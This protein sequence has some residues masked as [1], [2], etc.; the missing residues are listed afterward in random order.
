MN[1]IRRT[2]REA[3]K[4]PGFSLLYMGGV[5]FTIA[6]TLVYGFILYGQLGPVY[7]EYDR[8]YTYY[9][10]Q[11]MFK[12]DRSSSTNPLGKPFI[13]KFLRDSL[14]SVEKVTA[15]VNYNPLYDMVQ[16]NGQG[17]E[18]H[19]EKRMTE[20]SFFDFY[21]YKF[22]AGRPFSQDEFEAKDRVAVISHKIADRLFK[23]AEAAIGEK[24][25][26][27]QTK[28]TITGV[29]REG[30]A[31]G[32]DSYGEVF[33]P[34]NYSYNASQN[35]EWH[36]IYRG[37]LKVILKVKPGKENLLKK[38]L[39]DICQRINLVDTAAS[40]CYITG[41]T[42]HAEHILLDE[43]YKW[44][45]DPDSYLVKPFAS[46]LE[47]A[48]PFLIGLL[49]LLV[50]PALNISGLIGA[51]MDRM[52]ADIGVQRCFGATRRRL[53]GKILSENLVLTLTG[54]L[55]G[56]IIAWLIAVLG[57]NLL[58]QLMPNF[59]FLESSY[60][61]NSSIFTSETVFAP[62]L[63]LLTLLMCVVL[64]LL[65]AWLPAR[66]AMKRQITDSLNSKR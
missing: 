38:E 45:E 28:Y 33:I 9:V 63:F 19:V 43:D 42:S 52:K 16:T 29:F 48:K 30:S 44:V 26:I 11:L 15:L 60:G 40:K 41:V 5:A 8:A 57:N 36:D 7:P 37:N 13:D 51:R 49:I 59:G 25:S 53:M 17:P 21:K 61:E 35:Q 14:K 65:S 39:A 62:A 54:G 64:N 27:N 55:I 4:T 6:F 10:N 56:L 34:Y 24:I 2:F 23:S 12:S 47:L 20:P 3:M 66:K 22:L 46:S 1:F 18:F 50:I 31:L 58:L 32:A